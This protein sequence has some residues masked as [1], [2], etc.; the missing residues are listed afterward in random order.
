MN[1]NLFD[2]MVFSFG[3]LLLTVF[4]IEI[5]TRW[6]HR[7]RASRTIRRLRQQGVETFPGSNAGFRISNR[8][9]A[10]SR[11]FDHRDEL[12]LLTHLG[13]NQAAHPNPSPD[14]SSR[15]YRQAH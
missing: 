12:G 11:H 13:W 4:A 9:G 6:V 15:R 5:V 8:S 2:L 10:V 1:L 14:A 3:M 7:I